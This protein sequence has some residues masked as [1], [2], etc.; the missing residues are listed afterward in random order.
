M[1]VAITG[2]SGFLGSHCV[3]NAL[4]NGYSVRV[5]VRNIEKTQSALKMHGIEK[6][7]VEVVY[8]DLEDKISLDKGLVGVEALLHTA[9]IF[10]L[11]P[12]DAKAMLAVNPSST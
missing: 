10:S 1:K 3:S 8:A 6:D 2:A 4:K 12:L 9:A 11:S 5:L 7:S